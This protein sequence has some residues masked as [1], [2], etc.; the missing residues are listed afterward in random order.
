MM[1]MALRFLLLAFCGGCT[2][3]YSDV[4]GNDLGGMVNWTPGNELMSDV[5]AQNY[6]AKFDR[7]GYVTRINR[8]PGD[9]IAF[10]CLTYPVDRVTPPDYPPGTVVRSPYPPRREPAIQQP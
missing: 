2:S 7:T 9:Y 4:A 10:R 1:G 8:R 3:H 5:I 6:C